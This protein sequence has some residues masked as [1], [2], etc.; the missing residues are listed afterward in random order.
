MY[1]GYGVFKSS[2]KAVQPKKAATAIH[3][4][5]TIL[6]DQMPPIAT[7][8]SLSYTI[9]GMPKTGK[10]ILLQKANGAFCLV[11]WNDIPVFSKGQDILAPSIPLKLVLRRKFSKISYFDPMVDSIAQRTMNNANSFD[12]LL[13]NNAVIIELEK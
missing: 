7:P 12:F 4:L 8:K 9:K 6:N 11:I 5:T 2:T 13:G 3:N 10:V 1:E